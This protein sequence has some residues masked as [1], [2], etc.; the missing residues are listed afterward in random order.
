MQQRYDE[1]KNPRRGPVNR[2]KIRPLSIPGRVV[3]PGQP[4]E[5]QTT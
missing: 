3:L 5:Y 2:R 1:S 4:T